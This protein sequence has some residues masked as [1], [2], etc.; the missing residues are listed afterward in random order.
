MTV[1]TIP[2]DAVLAAQKGDRQALENVL[3]G[4]RH[5]MF[6]LAKRVLVNPDDA[7]EATQEILILIL[8]KLSTFRGESAFSTWA[9]RIAVRYLVSTKKML[10]RDPGL[11]FEMYAADLENGL[12][13]APPK[14]PDEALLLNE[15]RVSCTMAMLLCLKIDL[16]LAYV[17][18]DVFEL[19]H[20][21]ASSILD[22]EPAAYR[23]QLSRARSDVH[24]FTSRH[25]GLVSDTAKCSC[26]RRLPAALKT[27]RVQPGSYPNSTESKDDFETVRTQIGS[28]IDDLKTFKLQQAVPTQNCPDTIRIQL[29]EILSPPR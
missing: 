5:Q 21:E 8:T 19:D 29:T 17:L 12:V 14:A 27:G 11:T 16:R 9:Y 6:T 20:R 10:A 22:L 3:E 4:I 23:K 15:L 13:A 26:P 18:G 24:V 1:M 7:E 25:C 28:V 2:Q